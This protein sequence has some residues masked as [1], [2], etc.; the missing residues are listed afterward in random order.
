MSNF[1]KSDEATQV[2]LEIR[3]WYAFEGPLGEVVHNNGSSSRGRK[4]A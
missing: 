4:A 2:K 3:T 1:K